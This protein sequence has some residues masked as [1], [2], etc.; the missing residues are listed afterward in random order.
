MIS[1]ALAT[2]L[3]D[4]LPH[5]ISSNQT[6]SVKSRYISK[7]GRLIYDVLETASTLNKKRFLVTVDIEKAFDLVDHSFFL[8]VLQKYGFGE[9]FLKWIQI[10]IKNHESCVLNGGITTK[11]FSID[12]GTRQGD[13][14][15]AFLFTLDLEVSFVLIKTNNKI[16]GLD[17]YG[18]NFLYTAYADDRSF[19][20]KNKKFVVEAFKFLDKFSFF[21]GLKPNKEKCELSRI[22]V[23]G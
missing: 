17:I 14:I 20:F 15:S 7:S 18:H 23:K 8:A 13:P 1:K 9:R 22:G 21:S 5:L 2:R 11:L 16:K 19:F 3:K 12:R 10:L 6:A 4:I